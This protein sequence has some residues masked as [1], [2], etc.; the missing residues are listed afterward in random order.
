M[1]NIPR[2]PVSKHASRLHHPPRPLLES[3]RFPLDKPCPCAPIAQSAE[4]A[5]LKSVQSGFESQWGYSR[6][7]DLRPP[8]S[9]FR[10]PISDPS[11]RSRCGSRY[12]TSVGPPAGTPFVAS[13]P[14]ASLSY[15]FSVQRSALH[16]PSAPHRG[17]RFTDLSAPGPLAGQDALP[18][19][20]GEMPFQQ[21]GRTGKRRGRSYSIRQMPSPIRGSRCPRSNTL[22]RGASNRAEGLAHPV[23]RL[24]QSSSRDRKPDRWVAAS[25][26]SRKLRSERR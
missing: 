3:A 16:C 19:R 20:K 12:P 15:F 21:A 18:T 17:Q 24:P 23:A 10:P 26:K 25:E 5:D 4:A 13:A 14:A 7:S 2:P 22:P 11:A 1:C 9:D 6:I 8:S